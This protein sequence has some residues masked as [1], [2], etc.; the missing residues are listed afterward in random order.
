MNANVENEATDQFAGRMSIFIG[1]YLLGCGVPTDWM[2]SDEMRII[3][4]TVTD[5]GTAALRCAIE[6]GDNPGD[7]TGTYTDAIEAAQFVLGFARALRNGADLLAVQEA[8]Q[9]YGHEAARAQP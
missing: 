2:S 5:W 4:E 3:S 7:P 9:L 1:K 8:K 6:R